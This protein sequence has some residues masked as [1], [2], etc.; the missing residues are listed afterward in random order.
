[1]TFTNEVIYK[2]QAGLHSGASLTPSTRALAALGW[3]TPLLLTN[4]SQA[5]SAGELL[6]STHSTDFAPARPRGR[7]KASLA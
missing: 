3:G 5:S 2:A 4:N 6:S 7:H 1:M